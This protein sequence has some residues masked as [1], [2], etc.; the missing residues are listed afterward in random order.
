MKIQHSIARVLGLTCVVVLMTGCAS[1]F[2]KS[3]TLEARN[4]ISD[5]DIQIV[6][7]QETFIFSASSP[8]VSAAAGGG[9]IPALIDASIQK[10]RQEAMRGEVEATVDRFID[11]DFRQEA[12]QV[13]R[14]P[15]S[16]F[17]WKVRSIEV[18]PRIAT[19]S[20]MEQRVEKT[21]G[22]SAY[23]R[24][25]VHYEL[26]TKGMTYTMRTHALLWQ[27]GQK[28]NSFG[29]GV[30]YQSRVL[31]LNAPTALDAI[32]AQMRI[33]M[34]ATMAL[35]ALELSQSSDG[36]RPTRD[37]DSFAMKLGGTPTTWKGEKL[38]DTPEY[39]FYRV[40]G[41]YLFAIQK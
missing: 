21:K 37:T 22:S 39:D 38:R 2:N 7:P 12:N 16:G 4:R 6:V 25:L 9:L 41:N 13:V 40:A 34:E 3:L 27:D 18:V 31:D 14:G 24:L 23:M 35:Y 17:P 1:S 10:S 28:E 30:I 29:R 32:R 26:D 20:E 19:K 15:I 8:G 36:N 33:A 11:V 5:V